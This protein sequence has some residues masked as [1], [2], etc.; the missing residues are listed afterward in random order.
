MPIYLYENPK[1]KKIV[2][3]FQKMNDIHEYEENGVKFK[4]SFTIPCA[5]IDSMPIDPY[6]AKDFNK[7][8]NKKGGTIG[9]LW[10]RS[11]EFA[12][13]RKEKSGD[14]IKQKFYDKYSKTHKGLKH[15]EERKEISNAKLADAGISVEWGD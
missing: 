15:K 2:E 7:M 5:S 9:D 13:I 3:V 4:R 11:A 1:T 6:S 14:E 8:T 10:D 12:S